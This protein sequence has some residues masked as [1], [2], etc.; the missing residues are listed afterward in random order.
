M[1]TSMHTFAYQ[2]LGATPEH[3]CKIN[4][5]IEA[6]WTMEEIRNFSIPYKMHK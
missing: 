1:I 5:L 2:F 4:E 6:N 3:F